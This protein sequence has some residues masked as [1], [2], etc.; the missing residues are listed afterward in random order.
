MLDKNA[1]DVDAVQL[2]TLHAAKGLEFKHVFLVGIEE[3]L[4]PHRD[5]EAEGRIAEERR[6]MYVGIT[7]AERSLH[8]SW[9]ERRKQ[10]KEWRSCEPSRFI[11]EMGDDLKFSGG[12]QENAPKDKAAGR[13]KLAKFRA[14]LGGDPA[15]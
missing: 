6:L 8:L 14:L 13:A 3:G 7:R 5:A 2:A 15:A 1:E 9:C 11:A 10:G 12:S 4:L